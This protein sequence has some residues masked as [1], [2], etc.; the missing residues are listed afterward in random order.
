MRELF[1]HLI[2]SKEFDAPENIKEMMEHITK[3]F[4]IPP[5]TL[6]GGSY[7]ADYSP[8]KAEISP[9]LHGVL[10]LYPKVS[11]FREVVQKY[12][13]DIRVLIE[14]FYRRVLHRFGYLKPVKPSRRNQ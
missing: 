12:A 10:A 3:Q 11:L 13:I 8:T 6:G 4:I 1:I 5:D 14:R 7:Y 9:T 2:I